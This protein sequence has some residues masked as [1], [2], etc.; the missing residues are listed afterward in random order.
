MLFV[1]DSFCRKKCR[2]HGRCS[3]LPYNHEGFVVVVAV[4]LFF[5]FHRKSF[6]PFP[7]NPWFLRV[8]NSSLLKTLWEKEKMLVTSIF[9]FSHNVYYAMIDRN[10]E[11]N[12]RLQMLS[13]KSSPK[14][15]RLGKG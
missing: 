11:L 2:W 4:W 15:C 7:K 3:P 10:Q 1:F 5:F 13:I 6:N 9:S 8:W 14:V 12:C